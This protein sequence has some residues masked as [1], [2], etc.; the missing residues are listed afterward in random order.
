MKAAVVVSV[1]QRQSELQM[2]ES[3]EIER[4]FEAERRRVSIGVFFLRKMKAILAYKFRQL[5]F[6]GVSTE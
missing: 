4:R 5:Q 2:G 6:A 1:R 3:E